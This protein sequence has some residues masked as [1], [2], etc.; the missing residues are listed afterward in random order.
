[1]SNSKEII[2]NIRKTLI[3]KFNFSDTLTTSKLIR[4]VIIAQIVNLIKRE[5]LEDYQIK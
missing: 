5:N 2:N 1:M 4:K 3:L